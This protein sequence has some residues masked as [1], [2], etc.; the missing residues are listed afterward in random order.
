[1]KNV[2]RCSAGECHKITNQLRLS[3]YSNVIDLSISNLNRSSK[4]IPLRVTTKL[5]RIPFVTGLLILFNGYAFF[6]EAFLGKD[7][8]DFICRFAVIPARYLDFSNFQIHDLLDKNVAV[9]V[10][11]FLHAGW[12]HL[13]SNMWY[14]WVF[15]GNVEDKF[16]HFRFVFAYI[17]CGVIGNFAHIF[18]NTHLEV[19]AIGASG[20]IAGVLG[21]YFILFPKAKVVSLLPIFIF[22]TLADVPVFFFL[23]IWFMIQFFYGFL[24]LPGSSSCIAWWAHIGGF[25]CGAVLAHMFIKRKV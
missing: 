18:M 10:S 13:I 9:V 16:G 22:W 15:G 24:K 14:L 7:L 23:G 17:L 1:M 4:L 3:I 12:F 5:K 6:K 11:L 19:G 20:C 8:N 21:A 25:I 2:L